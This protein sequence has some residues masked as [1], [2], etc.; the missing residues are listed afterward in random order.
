MG[1]DSSNYKHAPSI[2]V[3]EHSFDDGDDGDDDADDDGHNMGMDELSDNTLAVRATQERALDFMLNIAPGHNVLADS[4]SPGVAS[5]PTQPAENKRPRRA[6]LTIQTPDSARTISVALSYL[7]HASDEKLNMHLSWI[8]G[9]SDG[10]QPPTLNHDYSDP[11]RVE[12]DRDYVKQRMSDRSM[13][14]ENVIC[15]YGTRWISSNNVALTDIEVLRREYS[16]TNIDEIE[17]G[18]E[19]TIELVTE[20]G[21]RVLGDVDF[22]ENTNYI[23]ASETIRSVVWQIAA[24]LD[25]IH[26]HSVYHGDVRPDNIH[27]FDEDALGN[28]ITLLDGGSVKIGNFHNAHASKTKKTW[29][30]PMYRC[31]TNVATEANDVYAF[32]L[33]VWTVI[34]GAP[35]YI[36]TQAEFDS[37]ARE[38]DT[39][40][41]HE[42]EKARRPSFHSRADFLAFINTPELKASL[43]SP[44]P[45][46]ELQEQYRVKSKTDHVLN[47]ANINVE[48]LRT[49]MRIII[50]CVTIYVNTTT[51]L[52]SDEASDAEKIHDIV[53][54]FDHINAYDDLPDS[55]KVPI[56]SRQES[57]VSTHD[58][59]DKAPA[60]KEAE[61][62]LVHKMDDVEA[63]RLKRSLDP[64]DSE[65]GYDPGKTQAVPLT[66]E[67]RML[68]GQLAPS[69]HDE[70]GRKIP[71]TGSS[72]DK[73]DSMSHDEPPFA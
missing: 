4:A 22:H 43:K 62:A 66:F 49:L 71:K 16:R 60:G 21:A 6:F 30:A 31:P 25:N 9:V 39:A 68:F 53:S 40:F 57:R 26:N 45:L 15:V 42:A 17:D 36:L 35:A 28:K 67:E 54:V 73:D 13:T 14:H 56:Y 44:D 24:G 47:F 23:T 20:V 63:Q 58:L 69:G 72:G 33:V 8:A 41:D 19:S 3:A 18:R 38:S 32:G 65:S 50:G 29:Y 64:P 11:L 27:M 2:V 5:E 55:T 51:E 1:G 70:A 37:Q 59:G 48:L 34:V 61:H 12:W 7:G 52:A 10:T 46:G